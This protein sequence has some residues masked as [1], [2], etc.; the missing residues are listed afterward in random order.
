MPSKKRFAI[1]CALFRH[2]NS[3]TFPPSCNQTWGA[4]LR[5]VSVKPFY[6][7]QSRL[8]CKRLPEMRPRPFSH[9]D[10]G[11]FSSENFSTFIDG[12][13]KK[14]HETKKFMNEEN[15]L[16]TSKKKKENLTSRYIFGKKVSSINSFGVKKVKN[17][18]KKMLRGKQQIH[19]GQLD[20]THYSKFRAISCQFSR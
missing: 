5:Q 12:W 18:K 19:R 4:Q 9:F 20:S 2:K 6:F 7:C 1:F 15:V 14:K 13:I 10:R 17:T 16:T 3:V 11:F 8:I